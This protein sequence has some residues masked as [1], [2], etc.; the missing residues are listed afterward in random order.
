MVH[1]AIV[2][3]GEL[4]ERSADALIEICQGLMALESGGKLPLKVAIRVADFLSASI[5]SMD[6][7]IPLDEHAVKLLD[8]ALEFIAAQDATGDEE[9]AACMRLTHALERHGLVDADGAP[10]A[11]GEELRALARA[12]DAEAE[13]QRD[14]IER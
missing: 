8:L 7:K 6:C 12:R 3:R 2:P 10:T 14:R 5:R 9:A 4:R 11:A 1:G 13:A